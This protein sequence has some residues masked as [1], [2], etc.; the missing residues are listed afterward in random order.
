[1]MINTGFR[2]KSYGWERIKIRDLETGVV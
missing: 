2:G 1:M